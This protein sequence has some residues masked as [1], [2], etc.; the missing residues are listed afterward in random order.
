MLQWMGGSRRKV[1]SSRKS[2]LNKQKHYFEQRK[3]QLQ[4]P[5]VDNHIGVSSKWLHYNE[6]VRS[7][8]ILNFINLATVTDEGIQLETS[9]ANNC[10]AILPEKASATQNLSSKVEGLKLSAARECGSNSAHFKSQAIEEQVQD[11]NLVLGLLNDDDEDREIDNKAKVAPETHVAFSVGGLGK[12][13]METPAHSPRTQRGFNSPPKVAGLSK[14]SSNFRSMSSDLGLE[15]SEAMYDISKLIHRDSEVVHKQKCRTYEKRNR[16]SSKFVNSCIYSDVLDDMSDFLGSNNENFQERPYELRKYNN[17]IL[18]NSFM[19][20]WEHDAACDIKSSRIHTSV[21]SNANTS[22]LNNSFF[23]D[24]SLDTSRFGAEQQK[25]HS[26]SEIEDSL[27]SLSAIEKECNLIFFDKDRSNFNLPSWSFTEK[28]NLPDSA[29]SLS[30]ESC[31]S[32]AAREDKSY[33][34]LSHS[35]KLRSK[36]RHLSDLDITFVNLNAI[37]KNHMDEMDIISE[38]GKDKFILNQL[39]SKAQHCS[40]VSPGLQRIPDP[41]FIF[42]LEEF[43]DFKEDTSRLKMPVDHASP[44]DFS[45]ANDRSEELSGFSVWNKNH[46][47]TRKTEVC[48]PYSFFSGDN[49]DR[50]PMPE[51]MRQRNASINEGDVDGSSSKLESKILGEKSLCSQSSSENSKEIQSGCAELNNKTE[52]P[53]F[54]YENSSEETNSGLQAYINEKLEHDCSTPDL[55]PIQILNKGSVEEKMGSEVAIFRSLSGKDFSKEHG[56]ET[57]V[58]FDSL[59]IRLLH[60]EFIWKLTK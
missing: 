15:L 24:F 9:L 25:R 2:M 36:K 23:G 11:E 35:A 40:K 50:I 38:P 48:L 43:S 53:S 41:S 42:P 32:T 4:R 16:E 19:D 8:D 54:G 5:G 52:K 34:F 3:R 51:P 7:L 55:N 20:I 58:K 6:E 57:A 22:E 18:D 28:E 26:N 56:T 45:F 46:K 29:S 31:T 14:N 21:I 39:N 17:N 33:E 10:S 1:N 30:E 44:F 12:I 59:Y 13:G 47:Q 37:K 27:F 60:K 49:E